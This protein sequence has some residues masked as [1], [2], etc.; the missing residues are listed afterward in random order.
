MTEQLANYIGIKINAAATFAIAQ[1][2]LVA[3]TLV[4]L[5]K[6]K[7]KKAAQKKLDQIRSQPTLTQT[8]LGFV[9]QINFRTLPFHQ[10]CEPTTEA[11]LMVKAI[12]EVA[13]EIFATKELPKT[14]NWTAIL[15]EFPG[16]YFY[17]HGQHDG[18]TNKQH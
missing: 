4:T 12:G 13:D 9:H 5:F 15:N 17:E 10:S 8:S 3:V 6:K 11:I 1:V 16:L 7:K 18:S 2:P 14:A